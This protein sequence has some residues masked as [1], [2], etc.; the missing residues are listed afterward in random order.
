VQG[1]EDL[2][3][4]R[5]VL[6][7]STCSTPKTEHGTSPRPGASARHQPCPDPLGAADAGAD[8]RPGNPLGITGLKDAAN[9]GL[10]F[11]T[12]RAGAGSHPAAGGA[13]GARGAD[14]GGPEHVDRPAETH[15]DLATLIETGEADCGLGLQAGA[16]HLGF[17][18]LVSPTRASTLP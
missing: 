14:H 13:A 4:G 6:A 3:A 9:R 10:R 8:H 2:A 18:P 17:L 1:L 11:A 7:G 5:A 15:A 16:G 12:R